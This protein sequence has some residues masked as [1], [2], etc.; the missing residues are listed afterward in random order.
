MEN[1][2]SYMPYIISIAGMVLGG[3]GIA[4]SMFERRKRKADALLAESLA[5]INYSQIATSWIKKLQD[6]VHQLGQQ[7]EE[8]LLVIEGY[9]AQVSKLTCDLVI[10][11]AKNAN[12]SGI[13][14]RSADYPV[15]DS[16]TNSG[17][18]SH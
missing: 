1:I 8:L 10:E 4:T 16:S 11:R 3:G 2:S 9:K 13:T 5:A 17:S 18:N 12:I 14:T 6:E 15:A 7:V